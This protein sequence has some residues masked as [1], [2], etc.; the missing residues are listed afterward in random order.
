M[1]LLIRRQEATHLPVQAHQ[2]AAEVQDHRVE[3]VAQV[4]LAE[5]AI[6]NHLT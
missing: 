4:A 6:K 1:I 3:A 2:A 5:V